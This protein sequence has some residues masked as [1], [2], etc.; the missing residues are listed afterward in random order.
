VAHTEMLGEPLTL[1]ALSGTGGSKQ[2]ET[3]RRS[4]ARRGS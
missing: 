2:Q 1:R 4:L 3:H